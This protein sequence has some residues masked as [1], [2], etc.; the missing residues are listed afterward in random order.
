MADGGLAATSTPGWKRLVYLGMAGGSF[1]M[2]LVALAVPGIPAA[3]CLLATSDYLGRSSPR[4]NDRLRHTLFFGPI[5]REWG[6]RGGLGRSSKEKLT[7]LTLAIVGVTVVLAA[8]TP[9][10]LLAIV[11]ISSL[12]I[13]GIARLPDLTEDPYSELRLVGAGAFRSRG[14]LIIPHHRRRDRRCRIP[15]PDFRI[16]GRAHQGFGV[17]RLASVIRML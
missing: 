3:P 4:L 5:L 1:A 6:Q 7:V 11:L 12:S 15:A 8:L 16:S 13:Y 9:V 2:T 17:R 10:A 14:P